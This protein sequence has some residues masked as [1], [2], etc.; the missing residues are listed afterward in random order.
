MFGLSDDETA[1]LVRLAALL[2][3][4]GGGAAAF[5]RSPAGAL[6]QLL[7]WAAILAGLVVVY[8]YRAPLLRFAEPVLR[9][10]DPSRVVETTGEGGLRE[11]VV[12]RSADGH[13]RLRA[14]VNGADVDF[15]VDT[16]ASGTALSWRDAE[17]AGVD[18][19]LLQFDR[20]VRTAA[21]LAMSA[22]AVLRTIEIGPYRLR[23]VGVGVMPAGTLDVSLLGM[24]MLDRFGSWRVEGDRLVLTP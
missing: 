16:G 10:L 2:V 22:R 7:L 1:Q 5:R 20:P 12:A 24:S 13:F 17:R 4:V 3:L 15:L 8:A 21:G 19:S 18:M 6:R 11:L 14:A 9:E 23:D